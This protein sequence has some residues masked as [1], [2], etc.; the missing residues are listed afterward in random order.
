LKQIIPVVIFSIAYWIPYFCTENICSAQKPSKLSLENYLQNTRLTVPAR[1]S[2]IFFESEPSYKFGETQKIILKQSAKTPDKSPSNPSIKLS[3]TNIAPVFTTPTPCDRVKL[4][5]VRLYGNRK[6]VWGSGVIFHKGEDKIGIRKYYVITNDH[7][8]KQINLTNMSLLTSDRVVHNGMVNVDIKFDRDDLAV[9][10]FTPTNTKEYEISSIADYEVSE[11]ASVFAAG[12]PSRVGK[13]ANPEFECLAG[14]VQLVMDVP[15]T[16]EGG[17]RI[18]YDSSVVQGMSGGGVFDRF[19]RLVA[20][21]GR[22]KKILAF[23]PYTYKYS[24]KIPCK[25]ISDSALSLSWGIPISTALT[26]TSKVLGNTKI[27]QATTNKFLIQDIA[28]DNDQLLNPVFKLSGIIFSLNSQNGDNFYKDYFLSNYIPI[29]HSIN[30]NS[31]PNLSFG[32]PTHINQIKS[33]ELIS[34]LIERSNQDIQDWIDL[35]N[36]EDGNQYKEQAEI[37]KNLKSCQI[38]EADRLQFTGK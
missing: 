27:N 32:K 25:L 7:V 5:T 35:Y 28:K 21:N 30:V 3:K 2:D 31:L 4:V 6:N 36:T 17:Y 20:F 18:G 10:E 11:N 13:S 29:L 8:I 24:P 23:N 22:P 16:F 15:R 34:H 38:P 19:G 37:I 12:F 33:P 1:R 9:V 26:E 14:K